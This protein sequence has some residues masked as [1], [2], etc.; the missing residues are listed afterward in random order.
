[1]MEVNNITLVGT[2]IEL[3]PQKINEFFIILVKKQI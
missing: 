1:M 3:L 2:D